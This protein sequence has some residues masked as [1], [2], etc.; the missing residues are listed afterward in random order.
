MLTGRLQTTWYPSCKQTSSLQRTGMIIGFQLNPFLRS[1][2]VRLFSF[3]TT[4]LFHL[5]SWEFFRNGH[6]LWPQRPNRQQTTCLSARLLLT[7]LT[8]QVF[9]EK[10][11][12]GM[13][14]RR[15]GSRVRCPGKPQNRWPTV[16]DGP[17]TEPL[18]TFFFKKSGTINKYHQYLHKSI[19]K[20]KHWH[21]LTAN[22]IKLYRDR[23]KHTNQTFRL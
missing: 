15:W 3:L 8:V 17:T 4:Q 20:Q 9:I 12:M 19:S 11:K 13:T 7:L 22:S 10:T 21:I 1:L 5:T 16:K 2:S 6:S 18:L 14:L 23:K